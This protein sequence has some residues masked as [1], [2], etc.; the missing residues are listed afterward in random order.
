LGNRAGARS[1]TSASARN[2]ADTQANEA[3]ETY[4]NWLEPHQ[5][6]SGQIHP[7]VTLA[8]DLKPKYFFWNGYST[9][10]RLLDEVS[11]DPVT[12]RYTTSRPVGAIHEATSALFPFK[13]KAANYPLATRVGQ[14]VPLDTSVYFATGD[15][16]AATVSG[17]VNMGLSP[18]E[19]TAFVETDTCELITHEVRPE[20]QALQCSNCHGTT[21]QMD[22]KGELGYALKGPQSAVCVQ[23][24]GSK[25]SKGFT[26]MHNKHAKDTKYDCSWCHSFARPERELR[27][28]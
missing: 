15:A 23:C 10:V 1:A 16:Q 21:N 12:G 5:T 9:G 22:L 2:A 6:P 18:T 17:L 14:L 4:R 20:E 27:M 3:T 19:P 13:V 11:P 8:N 25:G 7:T 26:E 28:P 24:H